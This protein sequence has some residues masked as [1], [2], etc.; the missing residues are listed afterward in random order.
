MGIEVPEYERRAVNRKASAPGDAAQWI[1]LLNGVILTTIVYFIFTYFVNQSINDDYRRINTNAIDNIGARLTELEYAFRTSATIIQNAPGLTDQDLKVRMA[2]SVPHLD[3]IGQTIVIRQSALTGLAEARQIYTNNLIALTGLGNMYDAGQIAM[4]AKAVSTLNNQT[5]LVWALPNAN[6]TRNPGDTNVM[7]RPLVLLWPIRDQDNVL[8]GIIVGATTLEGIFDPHWRQMQSNIMGLAVTDDTGQHV[9]YKYDDGSN[10]NAGFAAS[11]SPVTVGNMSLLLMVKVKHYSGV[12]ML[13]TFP[14][15]IVAFGML[16]TL[17]GIFYARS[18]RK[19]AMKLALINDT[20]ARKNKELNVEVSERERLYN[21]MREADRERRAIVDSVSDAIFEAT[22]QGNLIFLNSAWERITGFDIAQS[23][24]R[25]LLDMLHTSDQN[26]QKANFNE[27]VRGKKQS[28]RAYTRLRTHDGSFRSV[29]LSVSMLRFSENQKVKVVGSITDVE[30]RRRAERALGEAEKK[31]RAIVENAAG[32]IFQITPDGQIL[33]ANPAMAR[34]MGFATTEIMLRDMHNALDHMFLSAHERAKFLRELVAS[35]AVLKTEMQ[36]SNRNNDKLWLGIYARAVKDPDGNVMYFEGSLED[37]SARKTTELQ[38]REAKIQSDLASRA[39]S[40][41]LANMS[42]E[43]RTPLNSIIGF[44]EIIKNE[45]FGKIEN[46]QY[47]DYSSDIFDSGKRLLTI[48]NEILDISRIEAGERQ[49]NETSLDI[50]KLAR[51]CVGFIE[52]KAETGHIKLNNL[53][54]GRM[55]A[56]IGEE[57]AIKQIMVNLLSNAIKFTPAGGRVTLSSEMDRDNQLL[58]SVTDTGIGLDEGEIQKALSP[59]GQVNSSLNRSGSGT[60]L[61][62]TLVDSL[63]KLHGGRFELFSQKGVGTTA[64]IIFP[65][66]RTNN[67]SSSPVN[68]P[69]RD[70]SAY[71][72]ASEP[73]KLQ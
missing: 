38:L 62:L 41:F 9:L 60:G 17:A 3:L 61:G 20:L 64:T 15:F 11:S 36:G 49:L 30:D 32:G 24:D 19:Q 45:V 7:D 31:Y 44:S 65:A 18:N 54:E 72:W 70:P 56:L 6:L 12:A 16:L 52:H 43:L 42:H 63:I 27:L 1:V 34:I 68:A 46:S 47:R 37:I 26:E 59:F 50:V 8:R 67:F 53:I 4:F 2:A 69:Q 48:I 33:S 23:I 58:I 51:D 57:L 73:R 21:S 55:P 22:A 29:E 10:P 13:Q 39:K 5:A 14:I 35:D 66:K 40:E 28:Y 25:S 71:A